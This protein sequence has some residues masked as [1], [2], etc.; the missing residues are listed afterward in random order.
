MARED[1]GA[2]RRRFYQRPITKGELELTGPE[3]RHLV[4]A[5]R[6]RCGQWVELFDGAGTVA[7]AE[8]LRIERSG[9][10]LAVRSLERLEARERGRV[11]IAASLAK[12]ERFDWLIGKCTELGVDHICPVRCERTVKQ[13][14]SGKAAQR[15]EH[16]AVSAAK[17]CGRVFLPTIDEPATLGDCAAALEGQYPGALWL[18]GRARGEAAKLTEVDVAGRDVV[19][20]VGPEGGLTEAEV[21]LL[22]ERQAQG[23][24]L[25]E[26][27]L[28]IETAAIAFAAIL[29]AGR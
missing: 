19:A 14:G 29:C 17:Q 28:R 16:V 18:T 27:V 9:A 25:T 12:G 6:G 13:G 5:L 8:V 21:Q 11:V 1:L 23:V 10:Q 24:R 4:Q 15:Y 22:N 7:Q 3:G 26:T 2:R 20:F